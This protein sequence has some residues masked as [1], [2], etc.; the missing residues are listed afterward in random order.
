M[1]F[2]VENIFQ[3]PWRHSNCLIVAE[4][5]TDLTGVLPSGNTGLRGIMN[6]QAGIVSAIL[7]SGC[8]IS[9]TING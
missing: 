5:G 3:S 9:Q 2:L 8:S 7:P 6:V 4:N 1:A